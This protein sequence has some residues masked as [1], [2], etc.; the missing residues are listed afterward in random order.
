MA[1]SSSV[2]FGTSLVPFPTFLPN[3]FTAANIL[4][5]LFGIVLIFWL[6]SSVAMLYH[7]L[8]YHRRSFML[9][10]ALA[11]YGAMSIMLILYIAGGIAG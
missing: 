3:M 6:I 8:R 11:I 2:S 4:P 1:T 5:I 10:P 9:I 7:W